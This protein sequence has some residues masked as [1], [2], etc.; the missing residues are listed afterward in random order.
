MDQH[1]AKE[2]YDRCICDL[3][4]HK[5]RIVC[6]HHV[7]HLINAD[8][9]LVME[10][11]RIIRSGSGSEI[12]P[13]YMAE[14]NLNTKT[15]ISSNQSIHKELASTEA[16]TEQIQVLN[17]KDLKQQDDEEKETGQISVKVYKYYC[18]SIGIFLTTMTILSLIFMQGFK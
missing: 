3:L 2:I 5:T 10:G 7:Q 13:S 17:D 8:L 18:V 4:A 6:T 11:G 15:S 9:V 16:L 12:I 14:L 1:V